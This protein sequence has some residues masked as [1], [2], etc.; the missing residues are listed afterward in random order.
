MNSYDIEHTHGDTFVRDFAFT[1]SLGAA[2]NLTGSTLVFSVKAKQSDSAYLIDKAPVTIVSAVGGTAR[3]TVKP[4]TL[5]V[6]SYWY[7]VQW[8][9]SSTNITTPLKGTFSVSYDITA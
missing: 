8:T 7:D 5:A 1:D 3:V 9:D 4:F 6:G 2:I